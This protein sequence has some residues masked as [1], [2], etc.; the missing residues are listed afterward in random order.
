MNREV[1]RDIRTILNAPDIHYVLEVLKQSVTKLKSSVRKLA[2]WM[3]TEVPESLT[4]MPLS[5]PLRKRLPTSNGIERINQEL[6]RRFK[7]IGSFVNDA[8]CL[9]LASAILMEIR[10]EWQLG[11]TTL[12]L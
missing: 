7:V 6:R 4:V 5:E 1:T 2:A 11:K 12:N 3:E 8:S 9:R 10:D